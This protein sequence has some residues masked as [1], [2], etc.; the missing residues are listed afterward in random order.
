MAPLMFMTMLEVLISHLK[1]HYYPYE[2]NASMFVIF[3]ILMNLKKKFNSTHN[4]ESFTIASFARNFLLTKNVK[5]CSSVM[6][7]EKYAAQNLS[8]KYYFPGWD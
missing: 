2:N 6:N 3:N 8:T 5:I 4:L 1:I 7:R